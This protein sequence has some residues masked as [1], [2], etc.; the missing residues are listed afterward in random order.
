MVNEE[1]GRGGALGKDFL[2]VCG[3]DHAMEQMSVLQPVDDPM[4]EW[5]EVQE[6]TLCGHPWSTLL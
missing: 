1:G 6:A 2:A 3:E 5:V 4:P